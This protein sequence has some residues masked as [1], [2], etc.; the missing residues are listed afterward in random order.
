MNPPILGLI[1]VYGM[2]FKNFE[3][4]VNGGFDNVK[5]TPNGKV[6]RLLTRLEW[7]P[8]CTHFNLYYWTKAYC[9]KIS[10]QIKY[11]FDFY[12]ESGSNMVIS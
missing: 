9:H 8:Y 11:T 5:I 3:A 7:I 6:H 2:G 10:C 1:S 12:G 4:W